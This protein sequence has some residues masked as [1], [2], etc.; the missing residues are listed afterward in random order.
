MEILR[1]WQSLV[2]APRLVAMRAVAPRLL[3][4]HTLMN[5]WNRARLVA[6][7]AVAARLVTHFV[8][9]RST[10]WPSA[11][12]CHTVAPRPLPCASL[13]HTLLPRARPA[14]LRPVA[15]RLP[16]AR[17]SFHSHSLILRCV[18]RYKFDTIT[19]RSVIK[20]RMR[21]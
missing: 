3:V 15:V 6:M 18:V 21:C 14:A 1:S 17:F 2:V 4:S 11:P 8:A 13:L 10:S 9:P 7:R 12:R 16:L 5:P 19:A 20:Q